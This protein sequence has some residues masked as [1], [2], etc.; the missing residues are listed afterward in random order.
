MD[1]AQIK[2]FVYVFAAGLVIVAVIVFF[3]FKLFPGSADQ[4]SLAGR[5]I[6]PANK[7]DEANPATVGVQGKVTGIKGNEV[8]LFSAA[9]GSEGQAVTYQLIFSAE[10]KLVKRV[11]KS[12][13]EIKKI[14]NQDGVLQAGAY[15]TDEQPAAMNELKVGDRL[16]VSGIPDS[17]NA[18]FLQVQ[19]ASI[20]KVD[21]SKEGGLYLK[22]PAS[23]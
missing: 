3:R 10:S 7:E 9:T 15:M 21:L 19:L 22:P 1:K 17:N 5:F 13:E 16:F 18:L 4:A 23:S 12:P 14:I 2:N 11:A 20:D 8:T 6:P